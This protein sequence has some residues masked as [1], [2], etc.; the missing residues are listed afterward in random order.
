M[1]PPAWRVDFVRGSN[2]SS[3]IHIPILS[4]IM[5][6]AEENDLELLVAAAEGNINAV[7]DLMENGGA[8]CQR[9]RDRVRGCGSGLALCANIQCT[10]TCADLLLCLSC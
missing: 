1:L 2:F 10:P 9:G 3:D 4:L 7:K 5:V 6:Y 8:D